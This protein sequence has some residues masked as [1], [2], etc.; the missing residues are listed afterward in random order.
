MRH[1]AQGCKRTKMDE[2]RDAKERREHR[3]VEGG[4]RKETKGGRK[5]RA[6]ENKRLSRH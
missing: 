5:A 1:E 6:Q 4:G 2:G 3:A